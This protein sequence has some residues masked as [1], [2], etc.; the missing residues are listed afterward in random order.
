LSSRYASSTNIVRHV[1][2]GIN[3]LGYDIASRPTRQTREITIW[4]N[5]FH[6]MGGARGGN[7]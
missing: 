2:A 6:D 1:A 3:L 4:N 5:L 7:G